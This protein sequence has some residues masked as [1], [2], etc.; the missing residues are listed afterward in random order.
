M[1]IPSFK[2][3]ES[4]LHFSSAAQQAQVKD[5]LTQESLL[6]VVVGQ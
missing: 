5:I 3:F 4:E 2:L 6:E 1:S